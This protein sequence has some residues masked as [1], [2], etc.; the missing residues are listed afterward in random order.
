MRPLDYLNRVE[1]YVNRLNSERRSTLEVISQV[2]F[3]DLMA[4]DASKNVIDNINKNAINTDSNSN[5]SN[6]SK[7]NR[8]NKNS[9]NGSNI[10]A[11]TD[12]EEDENKKYGVAPNLDAAHT[13]GYAKRSRVFEDCSNWPIFDCSD[14]W[15]GPDYHAIFAFSVT[16][17]EAMAGRMVGF[18]LDTGADDIWNT[19]NPQI[20]VYVNGVL[21]CAMDLN[22]HEVILS[23]S[24][25][26]GETYD[27]RLYAYVNSSGKSNFLYVKVFEKELEAEALYYD[28]KLPLEAAKQMRPEEEKRRKL[29]EILNQA[30]DLLDLRVK[31]SAKYRESLTAASVWLK[32]NLYGKEWETDGPTVYALGHT[33]IDVAWKWPLRQTREK[34][35]RSFSTVLYLMKRYPEYR[36]FLSQPQ[37]YEYV[38]EEAPE[39]FEQVKER[40]KEGRWEADGAMWLESD[41][42]LTSGESLIRQILY[43]KKFF[44][45]ELGIDEQEILWLPDAFGFLGALPQIMKRS[46]IRYFLTTKMGWNDADQQ[47]DDTFLWEGI[48]GSRVT[49]LY[50]TTKNYE[51]YPERFEK[52]VREVTYNGRQNASQTMGTWQNYR[53]KELNDAVLTIYGYGDGGGGPTEGMLEESRR[54]SYGIPGVPKVKLSGL[55]EYLQVLDK[56]LQN[57]KLNTWYGDLYLEYHRGTFSSIAENKKNNRICENKNQQAEWLA[58]LAWWMNKKTEN[59]NINENT[60]V[61][62]N[63]YVYPKEILDKAWKLLLLNQFHDILPGSAIGEVYEQS[64]IDYAKIKAMDEEIIKQALTELAAKSINLQKLSKLSK[65]SDASKLSEVSEI[66]ASNDGITVWNP[67]GFAAEQVIVLDAQTQREYG[68]DASSDGNSNGNLNGSLNRNSNINISCFT[69]V[70]SMQR[71]K[72]GTLLL[73]AALPAKGSLRLIKK[74]ASEQTVKDAQSTKDEQ[75]ADNAQTAN[76]EASMSEQVKTK[77]TEKFILCDTQ[78]LETP[79]YVVSWDELGQITSLYDK[80]A[81]REL[82][83]TGTVGNELVVYE[84]IPKDYDAWNVESYYTRKHWKMTAVQPCQLTEFGDVCAVLHTVLSYQ[85]STIEQD[86]VFFAHTRRIDFKTKMDWREEQ[87]LVKAEFHFDVMTRTA[88]CEIPYGVIERPT[89]KNTSWQRAQ[90]EVCAHRFVDLSEPG[91]GV[92]LL[93]DGRY[94]YSIENSSLGLTLLTSGIFPFPDADKGTHEL[95]YAIMPHMG[96]WR[97]AKVVHEA[98]LLNEKPIISALKPAAPLVSAGVSEKTV[99]PYNTS[100]TESY[101]MCEVSAPNVIVTSVKRS[102][103]EIGLIVRMYESNGIRTNVTWDLSGLKPQQIWECDLMEKQEKMMVLDGQKA[104]FEIKPFEIKTFLLV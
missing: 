16:L 78:I 47:P 11:M 65:E 80:E 44:K 31:G 100:F 3:L 91:Y 52:P 54:L 103:D 33:H 77:L 7:D 6:D 85:S 51:T 76:T 1:A 90:F 21:T 96:D 72:D 46:G 67:L 102:E 58:A 27:I 36:F 71:M 49:G 28:M 53:N 74:N 9:N 26:P 87:Q 39:I 81:K 104:D 55:K 10:S 62:T 20:M 12:S 56:N 97:S 101:S 42:N 8:D 89:H 25:V 59:E 86:I 64:D 83:E 15:G 40:V 38:K 17:T 45:E 48:D 50:I 73:T 88:A 30:G 92:A 79:W 24:A 14:T 41:S 4:D 93:N 35:V 69:N 70:D 5:D 98:G 2:R 68:I 95:T 60:N 66:L 23:D 84:D 29:L 43:G 18:S 57:K 34:A 19:D 99:E 32:E 75:I 61:T 94:G 22:H 82:I 63:A 37:L 13:R